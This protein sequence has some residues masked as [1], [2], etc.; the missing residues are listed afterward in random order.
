MHQAGQAACSPL[1][2]LPRECHGTLL[3]AALGRRFRICLRLC[4]SHIL[5]NLASTDSGSYIPNIG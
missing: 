3:Q 2:Q 4:T 1:P 5:D